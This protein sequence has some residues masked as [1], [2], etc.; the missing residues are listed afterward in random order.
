MDPTPRTTRRTLGA[1]IFLLLGLASPP[2]R[3]F[4]A[5]EPT[6]G[7]IDRLSKPA[8]L[9]ARTTAAIEASLQASPAWLDWSRAHPGWRV[10]W[11]GPKN[12]VEVE[13]AIPLM[14]SAVELTASYRMIAIIHGSASQSA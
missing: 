11:N 10:E 9:D 14:R 7:A 8:A 13:K 5:P 3:S 6:V 12:G 4:V 2:A 1:A